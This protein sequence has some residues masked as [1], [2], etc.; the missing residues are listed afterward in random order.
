[1]LLNA[2]PCN[3]QMSSGSWVS[4]RFLSG[5]FAYPLQGFKEN[6]QKW[7]DSLQGFKNSLQLWRDSIQGFKERI[8]LWSDSL[9][10]FKEKH[11]FSIDSVQGFKDSFRRFIRLGTPVH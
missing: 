11:L 6:T 4:A 5:N 8:E 3:G 2:G 1:M 9:P 10:C 7:L